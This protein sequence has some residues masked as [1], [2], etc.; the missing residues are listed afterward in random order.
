[1]RH[2]AGAKVALA[3]VDALADDLDRYHLFHATRAEILRE[4]G[5]LAESF[6]ADRR[7]LA[8]TENP[9]ERALLE[10]RLSSAPETSA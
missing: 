1:V 8:L 4:L 6:E 5:R 7:A 9:A 2:V 10:R 3:E